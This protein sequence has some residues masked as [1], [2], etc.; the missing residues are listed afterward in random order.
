MRPVTPARVAPALLEGSDTLLRPDGYRQWT[1][2]SGAAEVDGASRRLPSADRVYMKPSSYR[3]YAIT[4]IFPDGTVFVWEAA[5]NRAVSHEY[6]HATSSTLLV[7]LKDSTKFEGGWGFFDFSA[8]G[9]A[10]S[11]KERALPES[12]GC[13]TCHQHGPLSISA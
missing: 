12:K 5:P 11:P 3:E 13:R 1:L 6:P 4:G 2:I 7:S 8:A 10:P 9:A